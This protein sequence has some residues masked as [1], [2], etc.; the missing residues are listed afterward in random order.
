MKLFTLK[1]LP[2][3]LGGLPDK[4]QAL[5]LSAVNDALA[6]GRDE[7]GALILARA[8]IDEGFAQNQAGEWHAKKQDATDEGFEILMRLDK[9]MNP[10]GSAWDV[11][12]C[13]PGMT[14]KS[15]TD[16][17]G[18]SYPI[19]LPEET[20]R[21]SAAVFEKVDVNLYELPKQGATHVPVPLFDIKNLLVKNKTGWIDSVR[22]VAGEGLKGVLHFLDSAKWLGK[23]LLA[24]K[25][26]G[27]SVYGLSWDA[28]IR[29][30]LDVVDNM[31]VAKVTGFTK[32]DSVDIVSRPAAGGK[33]NRAVASLPAQNKQEELMNKEQL[34]KLIQGAR[35]DLLKG[36][37]L[38][39]ITDQEIE[40]LARMAMTPEQKD[41]DAP[42]PV[43][44][45]R[46]EMS[47]DRKLSASALP[48]IAQGRIRTQFA[49]K[50]FEDKDIDAAITA[51][52]DYIA[53]MSQPAEP[54]P[55]PF[56]RIYVGMDSFAKARM[57]VDRA[58]GLTKDDMIA[59]ARLQDLHNQPYFDD[60]RSTQDVQNYDQVPAFSGLREM[61]VFFTGDYGITGRVNLKNVPKD[62]RAKMD[63]TS[64]TFS[65]VLG[66]TLGRRL[67]RTYNEADFGEGMLVSVRKPVKDYRPQEAVLVGGFGDLDEVD[68]E[69]ADYQEIEGVTDEE[70][71]YAV[72]IK[73]NILTI[74]EKTIR[75]DDISIVQRLVNG[76]GRTARRTHAKYILKKI[77]D[78]SNCSD[79]TAIFTVGHGNI[80]A[81]ALSFATALAAYQV[82]DGMTE[83]DSGEKIGL[84]SGDAVKPVLYYPAALIAMAES[85][86]NDDDYYASNDLT[87]KTRNAL[88]GK[89]V[90]KKLSLL[91]DATDWY[92]ILPA[93]V[94][95]L[96]EMGYMDGRQEPEFFLA[97]SPQAEQV[98]VADK[99]RYKIRHRYA[100]AWIDYRGA[101]K[102]IVA[103]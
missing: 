73:G 38:E 23:N 81:A 17:T 59:M 62:I 98:F 9:P 28:M 77:I 68:P 74:T 16:S 24:A 84:L 83:K 60:I 71:T 35:P 11:T 21:N 90:G 13:T 92:M 32:A 91:S 49:G 75:N 45:L 58:F 12:I 66:N 30:V 33:F 44:I 34:W 80:G 18:K 41:K 36:R 69:A 27:Q 93:E 1:N 39:T 10:E 55:V 57:A 94:I 52:K 78:N 47:L 70:S 79:G 4:G 46:C 87:T 42:D 88:K 101:Y 43:A 5:W 89:I 96:I 31:Q 103:G 20:L 48:E 76:L 63:I 67:V 25:S 19:Y 95:D 97:D 99:I 6:S 82:L 72:G 56:G 15:L 51:E 29:V 40:G 3:E 50:V 100:G 61:Y 85:I 26:A 65:Y 22:Y 7:A 37:S 53:K 64:G 102:A 8:A 14:L 54:D 86:V 2:A